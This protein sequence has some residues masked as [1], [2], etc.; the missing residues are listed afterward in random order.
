MKANVFLTGIN[1]SGYR[2]SAESV[3]E[4][5]CIEGIH[6]E[7]HSAQEWNSAMQRVVWHPQFSLVAT[8]CDGCCKPKPK[9]FSRGTI[10]MLREWLEKHDLVVHRFSGRHYEHNF[11]G[12]GERWD[13]YCVAGKVHVTR[14]RNTCWH[15]FEYQRPRV[16]DGSC[17]PEP[18]EIPAALGEAIHTGKVSEFFSKTEFDWSCGGHLGLG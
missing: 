4:S 7:R 8:E 10:R 13:S 11:V 14:V 16:C 12:H 15:G 5:M 18:V 9:R 1:S 6:I 2:P 3:D 17:K